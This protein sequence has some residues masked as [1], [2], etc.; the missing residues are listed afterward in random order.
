M[1]LSTSLIACLVVCVSF[2]LPSF[3]FNIPVDKNHVC[4]PTLQTNNRCTD[5]A[6][7]NV[8]YSNDRDIVDFVFHTRV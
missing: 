1:C 2:R 5:Q 4:S 3:V 6:S 8:F 7:L